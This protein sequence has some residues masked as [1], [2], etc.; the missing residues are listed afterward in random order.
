MYK[1]YDRVNW[2]FL[3]PVL[4]SM[5]ISNTQVNWVMQTSIQYSLLVNGSPTQP[6]NPSRGLKQRDPISPYLF[7]FCA[8]ILSLA[9]T[10]E[11][12]LKNIKG[13]RVG[14]NG[15]SFTHLFFTDD[16]L[17]F[18]Q[19]DKASLSNLGNTILWYCLISGQSIN[20]NK[21]NMFCSP[22]IPQVIQESLTLSL[23]VNLVQNPS[24]YLGI[25]FKLRGR[26]VA[27][28]EDIIDRVQK[29]LQR[30]KAKLLSQAGRTTLI[31][32]ILQAMPLYTFSCFRIPETV[33]NKSKAV[34]IYIIPFL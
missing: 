31:S 23:Q 11:E 12:N 7:L 6:F 30:W 25:N 29:K 28:I 34:T 24:K 17:F 4:L 8:N 1:A 18:F 2:N 20:L 26:R 19:N 9:L 21:F 33:C 16:S 27:E 3:K 15:V 32:S 22:N 13:I 14:R 5:N 10:K